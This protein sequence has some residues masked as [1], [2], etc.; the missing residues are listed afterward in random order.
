[1]ANLTRTQAEQ[2]IKEPKNTREINRARQKRIRHRLHTE[3]DTDTLSLGDHHQKFLGWVQRLLK[4]EENFERFKELYRPP[5]FTNELTESIFSEYERVFEARNNY[6]KFNFDNPDLEND[7]QEYRKRLRDFTFWE[8]EGFETFKTSI[9]NLVVIDLPRLDPENPSPSQSSRPEPYYYVLDIDNLIDVENSRVKTV[10]NETGEILYFFKTEYVVFRGEGDTVFVF[11]DTFFRTF[12]YKDGTTTFVSEVAHNLGYTPARS[13]W[14]TP[15]N[16]KCTFQKRS[17]IT[18]S[19]SELDWLLFF[20]LAKKYLELY[21]PFPL[22]AIYKGACN[23]KSEGKI[24]GRCVDGYVKYDGHELSANINERERCPKCS[25]KIKVGPGNIIELRVPKDKEDPDLMANPMKII[26]A[27]RESLDYMREAV[28]EKYDEIF[29]NCVGRGQDATTDQAQNELQIRASFES[30]GSVLLKIKRNFE[31]IHSFALD[32]CLRLR[33]GAEYKGLVIN[34]GD[35]FFVKDEQT[36]TKELGEAKNNGAPSYELET[37]RREIWESRYKNNPEMIERLKTLRH[38]EPYADLDLGGLM[39]IRNKI[40]GAVSLEDL[41]I[42]LN[43][44][45]FID[46]FE[47]EQTDILQYARA[48]TYDKKISLIRAELDKYA[49][50]YIAKAKLSAPDPAPAPP[51]PGPAA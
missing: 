7:A 16:S 48:L 46:R 5:V 38:L 11:D 37:R 32:T 18:N 17:P 6:E 45:S 13:F 14:T 36:Q 1:M 47:R 20:S 43:F 22:Y 30:R 40:P 35:E 21:A 4:S 23:Y 9:D 51:V 8:T 50:E 25:N 31:I 12:T 24:K 41:V 27:E 34:Y 33:Y 26:P 49:E 15:L 28:K 19:L 10:D 2:L 44:G 39:E 42:K 29:H 3:P